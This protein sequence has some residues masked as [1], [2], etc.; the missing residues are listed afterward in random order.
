MC[1]VLA[2]INLHWSWRVLKNGSVGRVAGRAGAKR[3]R[4]KHAPH[5][6][7]RQG[8][9]SPTPKFCAD[10]EGCRHMFYAADAGGVSTV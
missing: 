2:T 9:R 8:R 10:G 3:H 6:F 1:V 4:P 5:V 7:P